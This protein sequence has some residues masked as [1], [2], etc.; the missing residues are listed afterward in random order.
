MSIIETLTMQEIEE[1]SNLA[2]RDFLDIMENGLQPGRQMGALAWIIAKRTDT[3][4]KIETYMGYTMA[5][6]RDY[7][8]GHGENPKDLTTSE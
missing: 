3:N 1:L 2:G 6:M 5:Q 7:L 8:K 4:A